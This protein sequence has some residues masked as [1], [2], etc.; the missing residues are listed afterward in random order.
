MQQAKI[1]GASRPAERAEGCGRWHIGADHRERLRRDHRL[2]L[3]AEFAA[4]QLAGREAAGPRRH[5]L[6]DAGSRHHAAKGGGVGVG[7]DVLHETL[8][9]RVEA[10]PERAHPDLAVAG[11]GHRKLLEAEIGIAQRAT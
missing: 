3:P 8:L 1:G 11:L 9:R 6:A 4:D 2:F 10:E 5:D 7:G